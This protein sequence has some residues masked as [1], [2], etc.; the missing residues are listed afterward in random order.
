M[1]DTTVEMMQKGPEPGPTPAPAGEASRGWWPAFK[2]Y[3]LE[4]K[5]EIRRITWP[6]QDDWVNSAVITL[7][8]IVA[9][10][11]LMAL[12]NAIFNFIAGQLYS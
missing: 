2:D 4:T 6:N 10:S 1:A 9:L 12:Y 11:A 3:L 7:L 5:A 8:T